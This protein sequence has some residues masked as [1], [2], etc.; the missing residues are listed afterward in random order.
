MSRKY[1]R[2]TLKGMQH[3]NGDLLVAV[4]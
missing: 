2:P 3:L 1:T 4:D